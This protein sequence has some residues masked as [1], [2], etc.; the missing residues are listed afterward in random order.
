MPP[1]KGEPE[2]PA[3]KYKGVYKHSGCWR[4]RIWDV[5][6]E[7]Y[8]GHFKEDKSAGIAYDTAAIKCVSECD[9]LGATATSDALSILLWSNR[10]RRSMSLMN[11]CAR[12]EGAPADASSAGGGHGG[13]RW[14]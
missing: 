2:V 11:R 12:T 14:R 6:H 13:G 5:D 8:L 3:Q 10:T 7:V 1:K 9:C 4:A